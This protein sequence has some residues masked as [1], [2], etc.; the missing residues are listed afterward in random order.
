MDPDPHG[1]AGQVIFTDHADDTVIVLA[2]GLPQFLA[3]F[4]DD[5]E[6]GLYFLDPD[7]LAD[8]QQF[9]GCDASIDVVNWSSSPRWQH[10]A[11]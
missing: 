9:L 1:K 5:L 8:D 7:A 10:L 4:C 6:K 3:Q 11:R 2:D